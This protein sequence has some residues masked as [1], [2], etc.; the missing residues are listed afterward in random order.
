[1]K[2]THKRPT[3][4]EGPVAN[5]VYFGQRKQWSASRE[6][7]WLAWQNITNESRRLQQKG[8]CEL[9][10]SLFILNNILFCISVC[11]TLR[12]TQERQNVD[13][14]LCELREALRDAEERAKAQGEERHQALQK[15]QTSNEVILKTYIF[16]VE[17]FNAKITIFH[18]S[19]TVVAYC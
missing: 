5:Q 1:M 18:C 17:P 15:L 2:F 16:S 11:Q 7:S 8:V 3:A 6:N 10:V 13:A 4:G 14:E 9:H 19:Y 12:L